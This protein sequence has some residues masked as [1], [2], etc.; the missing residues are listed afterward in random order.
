FGRG[1][2]RL[3]GRARRP[4]GGD[5]HT[6]RRAD[7]R[8]AEGVRGRAARAVAARAMRGAARAPSTRRA[9]GRRYVP[10][11]PAVAQAGALRPATRANPSQPPNTAATP[12]NVS[13]IRPRL[14]WLRSLRHEPRTCTGRECEATTYAADRILYAAAALMPT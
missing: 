3:R 14:R 5:A 12:A 11:R 4:G 9:H 10:A 7:R 13:G 2:R 6:P 8:G 1:H